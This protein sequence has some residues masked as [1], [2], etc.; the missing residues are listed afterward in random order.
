MKID[1]DVYGVSSFFGIDPALIQ[2]VVAAEGD[3]VRAVRCSVPTVQTRDEA[4]K[5]TAR[6][7]ARAMCDWIKGGGREGV[8]HRE[9]FINFW[10]QRWAP[11]GAANDPQ[12]LNVN[13]ARNV[14]RL[15]REG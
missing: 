4:L 3:I 7:A 8:V 12:N 11:P 15:W 5:I 1:P 9:A 2:A 13:W 10:G 6:S 14:V